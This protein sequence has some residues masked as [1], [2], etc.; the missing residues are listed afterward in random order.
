MFKS[1]NHS[2]CV[3]RSRNPLLSRFQCW[4]TMNSWKHTFHWPEKLSSPL[5]CKRLTNYTMKF[6]AITEALWWTR[7]FHHPWISGRDREGM[8]LWIGNRMCVCTNG[9][10]LKVGLNRQSIRHK[11]NFGSNIAS[12]ING[13]HACH[14]SRELATGCFKVRPPYRSPACGHLQ[15]GR[16]VKHPVEWPDGHHPMANCHRSIPG[17]LHA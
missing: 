14:T 13:G 15:G 4:F 3:S 7:W 1:R 12:R 17:V 5:R 11:R 2:F 16:I 10:S 9:W 6:S 8:E